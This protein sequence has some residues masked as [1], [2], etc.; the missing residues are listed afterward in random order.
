[1]EDKLVTVAIHTFEK[2][3]IL[4]SLLESEGIE[5]Y[6]HNVN[7]IQP[8][9]SAGVRVRIKESDLPKALVIIEQMNLSLEDK[10]EIVDLEN[11]NKILVPV[12]FSDYSMKACDLAFNLAQSIDAEIVVFHAYYTPIYNNVLLMDAIPTSVKDDES[13]IRIVKQA[14][15]DM[16]NLTNLLKRKI[17][18]GSLPD[19]K[20]TTILK[21][22]I[23]EEEIIK[24]SKEYHPSIVFMGTRGKDRKELDL[25][26]SVTAEIIERSNI[27]VFAIP[28]NNKL[29]DFNDVKNIAFTTNFEPKDLL[30]F[31]KLVEFLQPLKYKVHFVHIEQNKDAWNEIK[32]AGIKQYFNKQYPDI[33]TDY[34]LI[35]DKEILTALDSFVKEKN[36]DI[37]SLTTHK[38]NIF[39]RLFNPSIARKMI[40]HANTPMLIFHA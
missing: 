19:I 5:T 23:P 11:E 39:S 12:D 36:I 4:K 3:Q 9:V 6:I 18:N 13:I 15:A 29:N 37:I 35:Q 28:E 22:G 30:A 14:K 17:E 34:I 10:K 20:F 32:L 40:F 26:G 24:F 38:R 2:A 25:I 33:E 27:P 8:V 16:E 7:L 1:M 31:E 21:D